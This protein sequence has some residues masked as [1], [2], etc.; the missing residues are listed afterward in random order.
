MELPAGL[1]CP[2]DAVELFDGCGVRHGAI[3]EGEAQA[4]HAVCHKTD[5]ALAA[6]CLED[7]GCDL[8][9]VGH[10]G[11]LSRIAMAGEHALTIA[12]IARAYAD[13]LRN[14]LYALIGVRAVPIPDSY[15]YAL[16]LL[17]GRATSEREQ[18]RLT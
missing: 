16:G 6:D 4:G 8:F 10:S 18:I 5:V 1:L 15:L 7:V 3:F 12:G 9:I 14:G 2:E 17:P 11:L 13:A